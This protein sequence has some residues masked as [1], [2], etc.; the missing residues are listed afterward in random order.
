MNSPEKKQQQN[1]PMVN[2]AAS[3]PRIIAN[4]NNNGNTG[5]IGSPPGATGTSPMRSQSGGGQAPSIAAE[6][7]AAVSRRPPPPTI[8]RNTPSSLSIQ[9]PV[10]VVDSVENSATPPQKREGVS[11]MKSAS[12]AGR[13]FFQ[14]RR[15]GSV[16]SAVLASTPII[17]VA[18]G[19]GF[20]SCRYFLASL[21]A[22]FQLRCS[23]PSFLLLVF[24]L[25]FV[26]FFHR[27][28]RF[29][30]FSVL[31]VYYSSSEFIKFCK[32]F[33]KIPFPIA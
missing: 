4:S 12:L 28:S 8:A 24:F 11:R 5:K 21:L 32:F 33:R 16:P 29:S 27:F 20:G 9:M 14:D 15:K 26:G 18:V 7:E 25:T 10:G 22:C 6:N 23:I 3:N 1:R 17:G 31:F 30:L 13:T 2:R 19:D